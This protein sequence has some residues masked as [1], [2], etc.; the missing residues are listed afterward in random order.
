MSEGDL[1]ARLPWR[2]G[3][4]LLRMPHIIARTGLCRS[5]LY[6]RIR[7]GIFPKSRGY[8]DSPKKR[9][10]LESHIDAWINTHVEFGDDESALAAQQRLVMQ[11][12]EAQAALPISPRAIS[13]GGAFVFAPEKPPVVTH[14]AVKRE[15]EAQLAGD[16]EPIEAAQTRTV[17]SPAT[18][19]AG[20]PKVLAPLPIQTKSPSSG[21]LALPP[22]TILRGRLTARKLATATGSIFYQ[23]KPCSA[24]HDG[25]R[26]ASTGACVVCVQAKDAIRRSA[27][28]AR[29]RPRFQS[30][31]PGP[32]SPRGAGRFQKVDSNEER[33]RITNFLIATC[34]M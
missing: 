17:I 18:R 29:S 11:I 26:Y 14:V 5:E 19:R 25:N 12:D 1:D 27:D 2:R 6:R 9:F 22:T 16:A 3:E 21:A 31:S 30:I 24:G 33:D 23:G 7:L 8:A 28:T 15:F 32:I 4:T 20:R 10:W 34:F 13:P